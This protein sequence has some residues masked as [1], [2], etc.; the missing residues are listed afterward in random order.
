MKFL[1]LVFAQCIGQVNC[2]FNVCALLLGLF[3][4]NAQTVAAEEGPPAVQVKV[5]QLSAQQVPVNIE[6]PSLL[7]ASEDVEI[8][9]Q[10]PG[11]VEK[12]HFRDGQQVEKGDVLYSLE[13]LQLAAAVDREKADQAALTARLEQANRNLRRVNALKSQR[14]IAQKDVDDA[15]SAKAIATAD[16]QAANARIQQ[17]EVNLAYAEVKAPIAGIL[18]R[19]L[20]STGDFVQGAEDVLVQLSQIQPI[21]ARFSVPTRA[22]DAIKAEA[23]SGAVVLSPQSDWLAQL[24]FSFNQ[25]HGETGK[26]DFIDARV[27]PLTGSQEGL[28][29]FP[30][31]KGTLMPG[32]Y[33]RIFVQGAHRPNA[34]AV[35]QES[36]LD[37]PQGKF[38]YR[39]AKQEN[40]YVAQ[41]QPVTV[42]EWIVIDQKNYWI[43][44][45]GLVPDDQ[46][47]ISGHARIFA[48]MSQVQAV[49]PLQVQ[50]DDGK[51]LSE[52]SI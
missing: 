28:A 32:Q 40:M 36:V 1:K 12:V 2:I 51:V 44:R 13:S 34:I 30:N 49:G 11:R 23:A 33:L 52:Q 25:F 39:Y 6:L 26:V 35:P 8:R 22:Y 14:A 42:G 5:M 41:P 38:V 20:F 24:K 18:S 15:V 47:I 50:G 7:L 19:S 21:R 46:I 9:A 27:N 45:Q 43:I 48:P 16:I 10:V 31:A 3:L 29:S 17:A 4:M 37:G